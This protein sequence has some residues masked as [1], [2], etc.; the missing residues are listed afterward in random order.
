MKYI[1]NLNVW[2]NY[3][4]LASTISFDSYIKF[5]KTHNLKALALTDKNVMYGAYEFY[6]KCREN[7]IKPIIGLDCQWHD[8]A[9]INLTIIAVNNKGYETLM[10]LASFLN[11]TQQY[12][13]LK[14]VQTNL[15]NND[16]LF[17][18]IKA[19]HHEITKLSKYYQILNINNNDFVY[20][21]VNYRN[22][23]QLAKYENIT[24]LLVAID[25]VKYLTKTD[26][27]LLQLLQ[28]IKDHLLI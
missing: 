5:A 3:S 21:G 4:F 12:L 16:N 28:A 15:V 19:E 11:T 25:T 1:V 24:K 18:I 26:A 27:S 23:K 2:S 14:E 17:V 9:I 8:E 7:A 20:I 10:I 13:T 22:I 6:Q